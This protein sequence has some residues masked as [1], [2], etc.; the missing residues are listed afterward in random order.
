MTRDLPRDSRR[1]SVG[2]DEIDSAAMPAL[3]NPSMDPIGPTTPPP[4]RSERVVDATCL[5][6]R[7]EAF[8]EWTVVEVEANGVPGAR[9]PRCLLFSRQDCIRRVWEYP[10]N[11]RQLDATALAVL[12][13]HR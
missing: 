11:W 9:G 3:H 13:W 12:S 5:R 4:V 7:D 6:Y 8:V 1:E 2:A 10:T